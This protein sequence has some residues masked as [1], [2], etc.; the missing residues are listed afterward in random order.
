MTR[1]FIDKLVDVL[2]VGNRPLRIFLFGGVLIAYFTIPLLGMIFG[3]DTDS[4]AD[5]DLPNAILMAFSIMIGF[6][7]SYSL[8]RFLENY[9]QKHADDISE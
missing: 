6:A 1:G 7:T 3:I 4:G 5:I 9:Q 8:M 2:S